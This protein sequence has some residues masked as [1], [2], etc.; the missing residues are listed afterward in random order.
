MFVHM[1]MLVKCCNDMIA[2]FIA[3]LM[4]YLVELF[5]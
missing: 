1:D 3:M 5:R 4:L 2:D